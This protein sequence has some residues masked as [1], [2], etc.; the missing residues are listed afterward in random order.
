[1]HCLTSLTIRSDNDAVV[2]Y[3]GFEFPHINLPHINNSDFNSEI[4]YKDG[5]LLFASWHNYI[6]TAQKT[7]QR[8]LDRFRNV[9]LGNQKVYFIRS[10]TTREQGLITQE[11]AIILRNKIKSKYPNL[12]FLLIIISNSEEF[13]IP[14]NIDGIKNYYGC[15]P[16]GLEW[17]SRWE[18]I[19]NDACSS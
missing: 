5:N 13:N 15:P 10:T 9:C 8:R 17:K 1:V 6:A 7:F 16:S 4:E 2:D 14:W 19:L 11:Q 18:E 3:Y 12:D